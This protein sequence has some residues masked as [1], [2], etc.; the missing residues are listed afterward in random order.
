MMEK[1][2]VVE[3]KRTPDHEFTRPD[4]HW[5][6]QAAEIFQQPKNFTIGWDPAEDQDKASTET[7]DHGRTK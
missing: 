1:R 7:E 2:N 3:E 5:D 4:E 6:K